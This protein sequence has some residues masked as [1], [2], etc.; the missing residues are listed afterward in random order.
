MI[1]YE[2]HNHF[3]ESNFANN[4][5]RVNSLKHTVSFVTMVSA[6]LF[7]SGFMPI[8]ALANDG[9]IAMGG[10][11]KLLSGHPSV[12]MQSEVINMKVGDSKVVVECNF[13]F[14]NSG[15][16]CIVRMGFP[17][18]GKGASDPDEEKE[19]KGLEN[20]H[21]ETT[22]KS[23]KSWVDGRE[24]T[25][26]LIRSNLPGHYWHTKTV[27]FPANSSVKIKDVYVQDVSGGIVS[28]RSTYSSASHVAYVLHTG[29]SWNGKIGS[30]TINVT[31]SNTVVDAPLHPVLNVVDASKS[32]DDGRDLNL[33]SVVNRAVV[34]KGPAVPKVL[35]RTL[36]FVRKDWR[37]TAKDDIEITFAFR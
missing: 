11:P 30:S 7:A 8:R 6:L 5:Q 14:V 15:K 26:K 16:E 34:W 37:P 25:T 12:R 1:A 18:V 32:H 3:S 22:F 19:R 24:V 23:F 17:D 31:F 21:P 10:S 4:D 2:I 33:K 36:T 29:S 13:V 20:T 27:K 28:L 9:G 35:G